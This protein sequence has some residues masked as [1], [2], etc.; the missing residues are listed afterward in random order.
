L[1]L[2]IA[3][4][5]FQSDTQN[6]PVLFDFL[7]WLN[8]DLMERYRAV[9]QNFTVFYRLNAIKIAQKKFIFH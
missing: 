7:F 4:N 2:P 3:I 6:I 1:A 9:D 5:S 8:R